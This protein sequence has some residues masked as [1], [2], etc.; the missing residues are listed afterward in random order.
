MGDL[1]SGILYRSAASHTGADLTTAERHFFMVSMWRFGM[2]DVSVMSHITAEQ[3][4]IDDDV[5]IWYM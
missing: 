2:D 5:G 1:H 4:W 3:G